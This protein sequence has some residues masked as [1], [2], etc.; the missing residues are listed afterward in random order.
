[1]NISALLARKPAKIPPRPSVFLRFFAPAL[2]FVL[3]G[4]RPVRSTPMKNNDDTP[5]TDTNEVKQ[6]INYVKQ[7]KLDQG[8]VQLI[9]KLL[10]I[11]V[12]R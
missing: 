8:D 9:E 3:L 4:I 7:G 12:V 5:T 2:A 11:Q 1:L 10:C 6:L